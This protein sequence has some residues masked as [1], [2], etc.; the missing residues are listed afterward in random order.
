MIEDMQLR[1]LSASTQE[2]Y[3]RAVRQLTEYVKHGSEKV[4]EEEIRRYFLLLANEKKSA[5]STSTIAL[6]G[7]K[8]FYEHTLHRDLPVLQ[9]VRPAYEHKLPVV[10]SREEVQRVL[11]EVR[12]PVYRTCL[13]T[14]YSCG[15]RLYGRGPTAGH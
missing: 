15:L 3:I 8:F 5:R 4:T 12:I 6:C 1:G 13:T 2:L 9:L 14:I 7:I 11:A 10:L